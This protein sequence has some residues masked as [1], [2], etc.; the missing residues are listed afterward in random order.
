MDVTIQAQTPLSSD[1]LPEAGNVEQIL[2]P[3][4]EFGSACAP[5]SL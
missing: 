4:A 2:N 5:F 3:F 1:K